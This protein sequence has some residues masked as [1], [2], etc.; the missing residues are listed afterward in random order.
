M[1]KK[2]GYEH[3]IGT[4]SKNGIT[5][6]RPKN[7]DQSGNRTDPP[8]KLDKVVESV[9]GMGGSRAIPKPK[10]KRYGP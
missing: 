10:V 7:I 3:G 6:A 8:R 2:Q 5:L 1:A 9:S 4:Y